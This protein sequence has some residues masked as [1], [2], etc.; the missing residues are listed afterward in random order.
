M[1]VRLENFSAEEKT[2]LSSIMK[3]KL[4]IFCGIYISV[5][6]FSVG[7]IVYFNNHSENYYFENHL[8]VINVV[9]VFISVICARMVVSEAMDYR[10]E[11]KSPH[12]K[13]IE[14][15]IIG[16][17][18]GKIMLGNKLFA[19]DDFLFGAPDFNSFQNG[20]NVRIELSAKSDMLFSIK[21]I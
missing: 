20:D 12:K 14:T 13:V 4:F 8:E 16:R 11:I 1:S 21:R 19:Q 9:F 2:K 7:F 15:K 10:K 17:K 18:E 6:L 3:K 5:I